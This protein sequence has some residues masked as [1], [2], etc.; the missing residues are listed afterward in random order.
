MHQ[1]VFG[2][3]FGWVLDRVRARWKN[4]ATA[5]GGINFDGWYAGLG[6]DSR[7]TGTSTKPLPTPAP[8]AGRSTAATSSTSTSH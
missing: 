3:T 6:S 1:N 8:K 2:L 7:N 4:M 5:T